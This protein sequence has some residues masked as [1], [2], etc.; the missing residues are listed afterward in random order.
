MSLSNVESSGRVAS[1]GAQRPVLAIVTPT[2]P[3]YRE[4]VHRRIVSEM[5]EYKLLTIN[6]HQDRWR[7]WQ[8]KDG[9]AIGLLDLSGGPLPDGLGPVR[10]W[11]RF[12]HY[13]RQGK[14]IVA[15]LEQHSAKAVVLNGY[16][17]LAKL[18]VAKWCRRAGVPC[19]LFGDS[20]IASEKNL[21]G[22]KRMLKQRYV[23]W[24][25]SLVSGCLACGRMGVDYWKL[26]GADPDRIFLSPYEPDY[27]QIEAVSDGDVEAVF[28]KYELD[29]ERRHFLFS[30][31]LVPVKRPDLAVQSFVAIADRRPNWDFIMLGDGELKD[32]LQ[33]IV[34]DKHR[35]RIKWIPFLSD[36]REVSAI[37]KGSDVLVLPSSYEP[38]A[39]VVNEAVA[40]GLAVVATN[41]VAAAVEMVSPGKSGHL[42]GPNSLS[43]LQAAME[44]VSSDDSIDAFKKASAEELA[45][46]RLRGDPI[47]G[48]RAALQAVGASSD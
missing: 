22:W 39:L 11:K 1:D 47:A 40:A 45:Q 13:I 32:E 44:S 33:A 42:V 14:A 46:W 38:W 31:R 4:H 25:V 3:P 24:V 41:V 18:K 30:G 6:T 9:E 29:Q 16:N 8:L 5:P 7:N 36:Q 26:Y 2:I 17:D 23:G 15:A 20:N 37:Y 28:A 43:E 12:R 10:W 48:L 27:A 35:Q 19:L 21:P 34:P